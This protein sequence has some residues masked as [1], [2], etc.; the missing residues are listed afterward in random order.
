MR[1]RPVHLALALLAAS[2]LGCSGP[3]PDAADL[4]APTDLATSADLAADLVA[5]PDLVAVDLAVP[6]A[7]V[8]HIVKPAET[9][10]A[11][12][13]WL[14]DH[15]AYRDFRVPAQGALVVY[16]AGASGTPS[17]T[18]AMLK[19]LASYGFPV[20]GLRYCNDY[21]IVDICNADPDPDC[22]GKL[23]LEAL[24]GQDH[25][26]AIS[27][28]LPNGIDNRLPRLLAYLQRR[29]PGEGWGAYLDGERAR[30]GKIIVAG[31]SHGASAAG[32]I[33]KA[34]PVARAVMLSGPYDSK[35]GVPAAWT[36]STPAATA[37][38][39]FFGFSH[40]QD[41]QSPQHLKDFVSLGLG[42]LGAVQPVDA[43]KAPYNQSH[44]LTTSVMAKDAATAHSSTQAGG[45]S[46]K[47]ADGTPAYRPVWRYLFGL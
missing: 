34:R 25:H 33:G 18:V 44:Q 3:N 35:A 39:G 30:W 1:R 45:A 31:I 46:P 38:A 6:N 21:A 9:D 43:A 32:R 29:W 41:T 5:P 37:P 24:D 7:L 22:H 40:T 23:R 19:E 47:A 42:A 20:V 12:D 16:L 36:S 26:P 28:S 2:V 10:P 4:A 13:N 8:E 14:E 17:G 15:Y 11:I 27:V